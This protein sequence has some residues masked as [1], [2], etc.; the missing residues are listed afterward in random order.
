MSG[1]NRTELLATVVIFTLFMIIGS[2]A[3]VVVPDRARLYAPILAKNQQTLW[4]DAPVPWTLAGL[5]EQ[6]TGPCPRGRQCWNPRAELK[7][8]REYG[9]GLGQITITSRFN[10]FNELKKKYA[11]LRDWE[12]NARF[13]PD[14]QLV[15][16]VEMIHALWRQVPPFAT[17]EDH[18]AFTDCAYNGGLGGL[19]QDRRACSNSAGCDPTRWFGNV[20]THSLKSRTPQPAYGGQSFYGINRGHVRNVL[21]VFPAKY[22]QFWVSVEKTAPALTS[23]APTEEKKRWWQF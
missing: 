13:D 17:Q 2:L 12:W 4:P 23:P 7:T 9:F 1:K 16:V 22:R 20:E 14:H 6:E 3:D 11:S 18:W 5:I 15:A 10:E 8:S 21:R 19:L